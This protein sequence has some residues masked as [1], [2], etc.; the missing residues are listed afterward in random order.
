MDTNRVIYERSRTVRHYMDVATEG[1]TVPEEYCL[2]LLPETHRNSILDIGIGAGRTTG[3][4]YKQFS[5]YIGVDYSAGMIAAAKS[6]WPECDLRVMDA[7]ELSMKNTFDCIL[8]SFNGIDSVPIADRKLVQKLIRN[9]LR[10]DGYFIFST[11][12]LHYKRTRHWMQSLFVAESFFP[13]TVKNRGWKKYLLFGRRLRNF[14]KQ[15]IF[16]GGRF[17]YVN[18]VAEQFSFI[19]LYVD[20]AAEVRALTDMG[21]D[22]IST[23]GNTKSSEGY[24]ENDHWVYIVARKA[25]SAP[26]D[27]GSPAV[28]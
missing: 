15:K 27:H 8:F 19:H 25:S 13:L 16:G 18:D 17:G 24:D 4:L 26:A 11:H 14:W 9:H 12:N 10:S 23:I 5:T 3:A 2:A 1:L 20:V 28:G 22:I 7:R 21:F 6:I